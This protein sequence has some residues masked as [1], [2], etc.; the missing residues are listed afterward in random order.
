[1][2][3]RDVMTKSIATIRPEATIKDAAQLMQQHN[4]CS[5]PVVDNNGLVGIVT[6]RDIV[7]RNI[8]T[9]QDPTSTPVKNVMTSQVT[10]V[11]PEEDVHS[12]SQMMASRQIRRVPVVENQK[13]I[14]MVSLGDLATTGVSGLDVEAS[15]AL[16]EISKPSKPLKTIASK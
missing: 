2:K 11:T 1:M 7:V 5:I 15:E 13:L 9:G 6:D 16:C 3:V 8:A 14:G 10:T 4:I 12:I